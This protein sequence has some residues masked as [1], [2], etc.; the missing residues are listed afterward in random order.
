MANTRLWVKNPQPQTRSV[1]L[2][3]LNAAAISKKP[4]T[5]L[6][7]FNQPPDLGILAKY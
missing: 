6:V 7:E 5:T 2:I 3:N 1:L 4:I